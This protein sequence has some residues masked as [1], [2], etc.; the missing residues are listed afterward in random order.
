MNIIKKI[1]KKKKLFLF[2]T[3]VLITG[4]YFAF[5]GNDA[6]VLDSA[7][8]ETSLVVLGDI[9]ETVKVLGKSKLVDEQKLRFNLP[10][11]IIAVN[12]SNGDSVKKGDIIAELDL[13]DIEN[14][15]QQEEITLKNAERD[16]Q[17]LLEGDSALTIKKAENELQNSETSLEMQKR[18]LT[19]AQRKLDESL[20]NLDLDLSRMEESLITK[21]I[22]LSDAKTKLNNLGI[23][24]HDNSETGEPYFLISDSNLDIDGIIL[25]INDAVNSLDYLFDEDLN[26]IYRNSLGIL[27]STTLSIAKVSYRKSVIEEEKI[28]TEF[29]EI[30]NKKLTR[31]E[32]NAFFD[33][34]KMVLKVLSVAANDSY[35]LLEKTTTSESFSQASLD[36][37]KSSFSSLKS[38]IEEKIRTVEQ[39]GDEILQIQEE[40]RLAKTAF[41]SV[42]EDLEKLKIATPR[43]K[44]D[45]KLAFEK[46]E[47]EY[48]DSLKALPQE[49]ENV[50]NLKKKELQAIERARNAIF[51][52]KLVLEK[53][54]KNISKYKLTAPFDGVVRKI[55]FKVGDNLTN[56]EEKYAY[57]ENPNILKITISLDQVEAVKVLRGQEA[58]I[59]FD[60]LPKKVFVGKIDEIN[61]SP[62]NKEGIATYEANLTLETKGERIFSGMSANVTISVNEKK[63]ILTLP[64]LAVQDNFVKKMINGEGVE[65][66]VEV[67]IDNGVEIEILSGLEEGD[68]VI[69]LD[70]TVLDSLMEPNYY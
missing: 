55:D 43:L 50:E 33:N 25:T 38:T 39:F 18:S 48:Y 54:K 6:E 58:E 10:G 45:E 4:A 11:K 53:A 9:Q 24:Y 59:V 7:Q 27:D 30:Y 49:A 28:K 44:E 23:H 62:T 37:L 70:Y 46:A 42:E 34:L 21:E 64:I 26:Q 65:T 3:A 56:D 40:Y 67:G 47:N 13:S 20:K 14:E 66:P 17:N 31:T 19:L 60:A 69:V 5:S 12:F 68:E 22:N 52:Q 8:L 41:K 61:Q 63:D 1:R 32:L 35:E 2:V 15:I 57:L 16:L 29:K 36:S 51:L